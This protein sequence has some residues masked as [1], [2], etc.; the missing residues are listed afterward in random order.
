M[1]AESLCPEG[2]TVLDRWF[3]LIGP[4]LYSFAVTS[5]HEVFW[6]HWRRSHE[7]RSWSVE[8][9]DSEPSRDEVQALCASYMEGLDVNWCDIG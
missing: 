6:G 7:H 4:A 3:A 5:D 8:I 2:N 9:G 1:E